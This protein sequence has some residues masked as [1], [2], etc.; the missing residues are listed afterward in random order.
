VAVPALEGWVLALLKVAKTEGFSRERAQAELTGRGF[1]PK[2]GEAMVEALAEADVATLP[3]DAESL[4]AWLER[5]HEV[6]P[7]RVAA[8]PSTAPSGG[9]RRGQP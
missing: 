7:P 2:D 1:A 4:R 3:R 5:A 6:L 9:A 8:R